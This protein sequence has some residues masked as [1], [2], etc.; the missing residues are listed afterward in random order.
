[1]NVFNVKE[2]RVFKALEMQTGSKLSQGKC[3]IHLIEGKACGPVQWWQRPLNR[4]CPAAHELISP[5]SLPIK[6]C[7]LVR[8]KSKYL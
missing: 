3:E 6:I 5:P 4:V 2:M 8:R 1:M 7:C